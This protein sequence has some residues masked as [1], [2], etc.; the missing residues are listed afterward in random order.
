MANISVIWDIEN[1]TPPSNNS[2]FLDSLWEYAE[3]LGR[4]V[5]AKAYA[6]W[7]GP[8]FQK[9]ALQ[10]KK[11]H[12]Y[13]VHVPS[14][15]KKKNSVDIQLVSD[16]LE[17]LNLY[18]H[19][20]TIVLVT[21]DSDFRPLLLT[22]RRAGKMTHVVC[23]IKTA[24]QE[25]LAIA[26]SFVDYRD[27]LPNEGDDEPDAP[28]LAAPTPDYWFSALAET[29][30]ILSKEGKPANLGTV[31]IRMKM[32]NPNFDEHHLGFGRWGDFISAAVKQGVVQLADKDG[33]PFLKLPDLPDNREKG[34][35]QKGLKALVETL[36]ELDGAREPQFHEYSVVSNRLREK[37]ID[38][39]SLGFSQFKKFIQAADV[40][41]L[42]EIRSEGVNNYVKL[43]GV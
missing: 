15:R 33:N 36:G 4:V 35:L 21:G 11:Y 10:L 32:L 20:D 29:V 16:T 37:K 26:D 42:V 39:K 34:V 12:F 13:L 30:G 18:T 17:I 3:N 9:L 25:L 23:D 31:K 38:M 24:S 1:V 5:S 7:S 41:G 6:D 14:E 27:I 8:G 28:V 43:I 22:L 40:R 2:L 19:I